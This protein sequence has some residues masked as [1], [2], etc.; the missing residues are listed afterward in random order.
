[1]L[2][3]IQY[4]LKNCDNNCTDSSSLID[5]LMFIPWQSGLQLENQSSSLLLLKI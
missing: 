3:D 5:L 2:K 1:M 4:E